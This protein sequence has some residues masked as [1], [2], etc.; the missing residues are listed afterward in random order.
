MVYFQLLQRRILL[1][2]LFSDLVPYLG[3]DPQSPRH[4]QAGWDAGNPA[5]QRAGD[6]V[7]GPFRDG[8]FLQA[9]GTEGVLAV[10]DPGDPRS[11]GVFIAADNAFELLAGHH[12]GFR[13]Q[14]SKRF[15]P[16]IKSLQRNSII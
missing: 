9:R 8:H 10:K 15:L 4:R 6:G 3:V 7:E 11:A 16:K 14:T 5:A 1:H 13:K 12:C 2:L